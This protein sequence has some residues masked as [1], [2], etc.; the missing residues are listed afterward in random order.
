VGTSVVVSATVVVVLGADVV[1]L[2]EVEVEVE[3]AVVGADFPPL[4]QA[5]TKAAPPASANMRRRETTV[6]NRAVEV[7]G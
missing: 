6:R 3:I 4:L 2:V 1:V 5:L 7:S